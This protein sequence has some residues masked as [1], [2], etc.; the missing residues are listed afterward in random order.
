MMSAFDVAVIGAGPAGLSAAIVAAKAGAKV[1]ALDENEEPGGQLFKQIHK[2][3]VSKSHYAG[4]R[5]FNIGARLLEEARNAGVQ[6]LLGSIIWGVFGNRL[7]ITKA[8]GQELI[9]AR[10]IVLAT[11]AQ[12]KPLRFP[13]WTLPGVM[14]AGAVQTMINLHRVL[15]GKRVLMIGSGNVGLIVSYQLLQAGA[16]V[17][18]LVE[19]ARTIGGYFVHASKISRTGV[20]IFV[21]H[22]IKEALGTKQVEK[23]VIVGIDANWNHVPGSEK[24]LEVDTIAVAVGLMPQ[25]D[26]ARMCGC[27]MGY[28]PSLGGH[29]PMH[30]RNMETSVEGIYVAGDLAGIGEASIAADE[31]RIAGI[32][33]VESLGFLS[34]SEAA[35]LK[36]EVW[37]RLGEIRSGPFGV[38][39]A[40]AKKKLV[41]GASKH[42]FSAKRVHYGS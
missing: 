37:E 38:E 9:Y 12:E 32:S 40:M 27:E 16:E 30:D 28:Y 25:E 34:R 21:S 18:A 35:D 33:A 7:A 26:L 36:S 11:G 6:I 19:A 8:N 31:G 39:A 23:A 22:T 42:G 20:P 1:I 10:K 5:G 41:E 17:C 24:E 3:F 13:G 14:T 15:P 29:V 2:F 4:T